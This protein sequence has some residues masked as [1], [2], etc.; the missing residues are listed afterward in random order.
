MEILHLRPSAPPPLPDD[1]FPTANNHIIIFKHPSYPDEYGQNILLHL[2][3]WDS[4]DGGLHAATALLACTLIA[5]NAWD[6]YLTV[7]RDGSRL[8]LQEDDI[9]PAGEYYF[10]VPRPS[11]TPIPPSGH[12][13][14]YKYP[15]YPSFQHWAFP[16][17]QVPSQWRGEDES[18]TIIGATINTPSVSSVSA[19]VINRDR[20]CVVSKYRDCI[21]RAHL[22]PR[23]ELD[24]FRKNGMRRY[25]L[26]LDIS[27]DVITDDIANALAMRPDIH[28]AFDDCKFALVRKSGRWTVHFLEKTYDLGRM[29]HNRPIDIAGFSPEFVLT[30]FAWAIFPFVKAFMEQGPER[31]VKV[32]EQSDEGFREIVKTLD[33]AGFEQMNLATRGRS[34]S[35]KKRKAADVPQT[36]G[37]KRLCTSL[38]LETDGIQTSLSALE[39]QSERG[40][41]PD[42]SF[43]DGTSAELHCTQGHSSGGS[44]SAGQ[45]TVI[46]DDDTEN[47]RLCALRINELRKRRPQ[48]SK[49]ICCDY[50]L[51]EQANALGI[52]GKTEY[53]GGHL[54]LNCLGLDSV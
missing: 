29:Y 47:E 13:S 16:H 49:L 53:G 18:C 42:F 28:R 38:Q 40:Y 5:C 45:N 46:T 9:L 25:N 26:R 43:D 30:R 41:T 24:W 8:D 50:N 17:R 12:G 19:A 22:C 27:G 32:R 51:A 3:A 34:G 33:F 36:A 7:E 31:L 23:N 21:E 52:P 35:P 14:H 6:G 4:P 39:G 10:H 2:Y 1:P 48:D 44:I 11:T 20:S 37:M 54:C 15:I